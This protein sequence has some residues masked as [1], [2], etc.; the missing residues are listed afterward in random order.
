MAA[1]I[2]ETDWYYYQKF[3]GYTKEENG[4]KYLLTVNEHNRESTNVDSHGWTEVE[5]FKDVK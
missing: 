3:Q 2:K 4:K 5:I 1:L